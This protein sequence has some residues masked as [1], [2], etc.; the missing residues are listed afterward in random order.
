MLKNP[1]SVQKNKRLNLL[2]CVNNYWKVV[3]FLFYFCCF[4]VIYFQKESVNP[5]QVD[6][7]KSLFSP[8][9]ILVMSKIIGQVNVSK[10]RVAQPTRIFYTH[11]ISVFRNTC[12][13]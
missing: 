3:A 12:V 7:A 9:R 1:T 13:I 8:I 11:D 2:T 6:S 5:S 10:D 4:E